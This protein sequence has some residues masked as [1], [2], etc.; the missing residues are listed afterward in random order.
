L[1]LT[2]DPALPVLGELEDDVRVVHDVSFRDAAAGWR[3]QGWQENDRA[4]ARP[5]NRSVV[6]RRRAGGSGGVE[7]ASADA[8][9]IGAA[10]EGSSHESQL[11]HRG[12]SFRVDGTSQ[13]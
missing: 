13:S 12:T 8:R 2:L 6:G 4:S 9:E 3:W 5:G 7:H 10:S 1:E 11:D